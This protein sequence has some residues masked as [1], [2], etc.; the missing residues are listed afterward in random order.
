MNPRLILILTQLA[1]AIAAC[2]AYYCY[3]NS[4]LSLG[5]SAGA[6]YLWWHR[7]RVERK[8]P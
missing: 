1:F 3:G 4:E 8:T 7:W 6:Y 2:V 5:L